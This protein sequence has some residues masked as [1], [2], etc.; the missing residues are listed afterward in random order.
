MNGVKI[1]GIIKRSVSFSPLVNK[2]AQEM[3]EQRGF[4]SNFSAFIADLVR[5]AQENE[6]TNSAATLADKIVSGATS[7]ASAAPATGPVSYKS[8]PKVGPRK[9]TPPGEGSS[10]KFLP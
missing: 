1:N 4:G 6:E 7:E 2:W 10:K 9:A 3:A 8:K 5:R